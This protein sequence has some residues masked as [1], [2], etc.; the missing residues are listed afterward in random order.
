MPRLPLLLLA[1]LLTAGVRAQPVPIVLDEEFSDWEG[2]EPVYVGEDGPF[3]RVWAASDDRYLFLSVELAEPIILQESRLVLF[4]DGDGD[5]AT[6]APLHGMGVEVEWHFGFRTGTAYAGG[7]AYAIGHSDLGLV[8]APTVSSDRFEIALRRDAS[9]GA[10]RLLGD[11]EVRF[12][13]ADAIGGATVPRGGGGLSHPLAE[14]ARQRVPVSLARPEGPHLRVVSYNVLRDGPLF[15]RDALFGRILRA[16]DPDLISFQEM[17][18]TTPEFVADWLGRDLPEGAPWHVRRTANDIV[19]AS[20]FPITDAAAV[21]HHDAF[22]PRTGA[23]VVDLR[24]AFDTDLLVYGTHPSCCAN[25]VPR[26]EQLDALMGDLRDR[27]ANLPH[28]TPFLL[29]GD[30]NLVTHEAQRRT[31]Q[32][33]EISDTARFGPAFAPDW[34]GTP[35]ADLRPPTTGLPMTFTWYDERSEFSPGRLDY[36]FYSDASMEA[37]GGFALFSLGLTEAELEAYDLGAYDTSHASDHLPVVGDFRLRAGGTSSAPVPAPP[38]T[39]RLDVYPNPAADR[40]TLAVRAAG[41]EVLVT[42]YDVLGREVHALAVPL[43]D[44]DEARVTLRTDHLPPGLYVVRAGAGHHAVTR[45]LL[46]AH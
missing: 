4:L 9:I 2:V 44:G 6:G 39:L 45:K 41:P 30:F 38:A 13:L 11:G 33:G 40:V 43:A 31:V 46:V 10:H 36:I 3:R 27:R 25:D 26:Q 24:P 1:L 34:D 22:A 15:G 14:G 7:Q 18:V 16:L 35:L 37:L 32:F 17:Y 19:L 29:A 5:D 42:L 23:F 8:S 28:G 12:V 20:R 21:R